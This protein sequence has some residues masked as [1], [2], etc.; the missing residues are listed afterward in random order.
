ME[1]G[2]QAPAQRRRWRALFYV[3]ADLMPE[4]GCIPGVENLTTTSFSRQGGNRHALKQFRFQSDFRT[5]LTRPA[6]RQQTK[7]GGQKSGGGLG[8]HSRVQLDVIQAIVARTSSRACKSN[9][10]VNCG[11][12]IKDIHGGKVEGLQSSRS[13][14]RTDGHIRSAEVG[15]IR[16][17]GGVGHLITVESRGSP[18]VANENTGSAYPVKSNW[19]IATAPLFGVPLLAMPA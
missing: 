10:N 15:E 2:G 6:Q 13:G 3:V 7:C 4:A 5:F 17:I 12:L 16:A 14:K 19:S 1:N 18:W 11:R 9:P 8:D